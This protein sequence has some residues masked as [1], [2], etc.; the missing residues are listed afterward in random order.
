M[1][2]EQEKAAKAAAAARW[3]FDQIQ[4]RGEWAMESFEQHGPRFQVLSLGFGILNFEFPPA[5]G[6]RCLLSPASF[7]YLLDTLWVAIYYE[8]S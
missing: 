3:L 6:R 1:T 7:F 4:V 5:A 2:S 8:G